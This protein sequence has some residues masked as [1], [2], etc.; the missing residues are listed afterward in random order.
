MCILA[1]L[2]IPI[3]FRHFKMN[4]MGNDPTE[5]ICK[6]DGIQVYRLLI[7]SLSIVTIQVYLFFLLL[8]H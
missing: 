8:I 3:I 7:D 2:H 5:E 6:E 4:G 1:D